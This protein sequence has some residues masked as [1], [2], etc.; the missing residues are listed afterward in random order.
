MYFYYVLRI[1]KNSLLC[2]NFSLLFMYNLIKQSK[3]MGQMFSL[4]DDEHEGQYH[5]QDQE[6]DP[7]QHQEQRQRHPHPQHE[8]SVPKR[9]Q[10]NAAGAIRS[11]RTKP[12][13]QGRTRRKT[14]AFE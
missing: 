3:K 2:C 6:Q 9:R 13:A 1:Q 14:V 4:G 11:R 10:R 5:D 12:S 8:L 7:E